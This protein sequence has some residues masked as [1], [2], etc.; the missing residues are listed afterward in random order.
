MITNQDQ[1]VAPN[2]FLEALDKLKT[3]KTIINIAKKITLQFNSILAVSDFLLSEFDTENISFRKSFELAYDEKNKHFIDFHDNINGIFVFQIKLGDDK[4]FIKKLKYP[5]NE[6]DIYDRIITLYEKNILNN[7]KEFLKRSNTNTTIAPLLSSRKISIS[8]ISSLKEL[9]D[10]KQYVGLRLDEKK[11]VIDKFFEEYVQEYLKSFGYKMEYSSN[12]KK[13][14]YE[15]NMPEIGDFLSFNNKEDAQAS[16][17]YLDKKN[18]S[19]DDRNTFIAALIMKSNRLLNSYQM[20]TL[21][22][23]EL[24][25]YVKN[26]V[27]RFL[28]TSFKNQ[29]NAF[30]N[31]GNISENDLKNIN[32]LIS[33]AFSKTVPSIELGEILL[34]TRNSELS[35]FKDVVSEL[36]VKIKDDDII[37]TYAT[38]GNKFPKTLIYEKLL[39]LCNN[40]IVKNKNKYLSNKYFEHVIFFNNDDKIFLHPTISKDKFKKLAIEIERKN[41]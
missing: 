29:M 35:Y 38:L 26:I 20:M 16:L 24:N 10:Y 12:R 34:A 18:L 37:Y 13:T 33:I 7:Q 25:N 30:I 40:G 3:D 14:N 2:D 31:Q 1:K 41:N 21:N 17:E 32:Y 8:N 11:Y 36:N 9:L 28:K 15:R 6:K 27:N 4:F 5:Y 22:N 23:L 39:Y 19:D